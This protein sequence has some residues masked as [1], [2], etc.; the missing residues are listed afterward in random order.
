[1]ER[2]ERPARAEGQE[3]G[4]GGELQAPSATPKADC[5]NPKTSQW[6]PWPSSP[7][8]LRP[9]LPP[10]LLP[11]PLHKG[12][13]PLRV[14]GNRL[15]TLSLHGQKR[16]GVS[17]AW[18]QWEAASLWPLQGS[19]PRL[20]WG[21]QPCGA[22]SW[23]AALTR[24]SGEGLPCPLL[25]QP[26]QEPFPSACLCPDPLAPAFQ[27]LGRASEQCALKGGPEHAASCSPQAVPS[28]QMQSQLGPKAHAHAAGR[29]LASPH[30]C[31]LQA[32]AGSTGRCI[33]C[34]GAGRCLEP[35]ADVD[36]CSEPG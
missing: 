22:G 8:S 30:A 33:R 24:G 27:D 25:V 12:H 1:M 4:H 32:G 15:L 14:T 2:R 28:L 20:A 35:A 23:Y 31:P 26:G 7:S 21:R 5:C 10:G 16:D 34:L 6:P 18:G 9:L 13:R 3:L 17:Q 11:C 29:S 36:K 19:R